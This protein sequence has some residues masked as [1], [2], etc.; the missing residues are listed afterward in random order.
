MSVQPEP[1]F[2]MTQFLI[3]IA[4]AITTTTIAVIVK[5]SMYMA[6]LLF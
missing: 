3:N 2:F 4:N 1:Q 6:H 5:L